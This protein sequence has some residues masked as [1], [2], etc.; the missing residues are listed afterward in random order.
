MNKNELKEK[1]YREIDRRKEE[2]IGLGIQLWKNPE[3][4][5]EEFKS[6]ALVEKVLS[7][8]NLPVRGKLAR[9]G[10]RA[11]LKTGKPGPTVAI[12]GEL[13]ALIMPEHPEADP[14]T[15]AAHA[16]GHNMQ[17]TAMVGA[18]MALALPEVRE[19]L[20]GNLAFIA[21]PAE[22]S[23]IGDH[24]EGVKYI[25][26]KPELIRTGVFDDVDMAIMTHANS[27]Y[28]AAR[29]SNGFVMKKVLFRGQA[30][31][32]GRPWVGLN[33]LSAA[34]IAL[35]AMD[36]QRDTFRDEDTV[37]IHGI[38][39]N[40]GSVVNIVPEEVELEYQL[41]AQT[42]EAI[43][44]A[45]SKFDRSMQ[46]AALAFGLDVSITTFP[47]YMPLYNEPELIRLHLDNL[48][49]FRPDVNFVDMGRRTSSTDMGDVSAIMPAMHPYSGGWKGTA[50]TIP[51]HWQDED[52]AFV[53][54]AKVL[55]ADAVDL[56]FGNADDA[57]RIARIKPRFTKQEYLDFLDSFI[58]DETFRYSVKK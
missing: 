27:E 38:I 58:A 25:G 11:D 10:V 3:P 4:G 22:E 34:R 18:A 12:L 5:Y 55:A 57:R 41:R 21:C 2:L 24:L 17:I 7:T 44:D 8:L 9:T 1:L 50:H 37:R 39:K 46:G 23:R 29:T 6:A 33:A 28:G 19:H 48:R 56:L 45:S 13:D 49:S 52:E 30:A 42:P 20:S 32:A 40:G 53:E 43:R 54:P 16:C 36:A 51:F 26:G 47:G 14:Q 31:H 15:R 35:D